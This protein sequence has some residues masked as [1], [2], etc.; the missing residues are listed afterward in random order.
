[1]VN[2]QP[3][4]SFC[5]K[6]NYITKK[7]NHGLVRG[8]SFYNSPMDI[9]SGHWIFA[10]LFAFSFVV[11]TVYAYR[12]DLKRTP[13]LFQGSWKF[14]LGVVLVVMI[15]IVVKILFRFSH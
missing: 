6:D 10:G 2:Q 8:F 3:R 1:M 7:K 4:R 11:A 13:S 15:L 14:L 9:G 5:K 12:D